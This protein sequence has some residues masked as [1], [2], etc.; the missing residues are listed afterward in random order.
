MYI[1]EL[2][3]KDTTVTGSENYSRQTESLF[4]DRFSEKGS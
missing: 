2:S 3:N 4:A 1:K